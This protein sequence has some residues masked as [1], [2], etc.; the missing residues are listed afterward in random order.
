MGFFLYQKNE[1]QKDGLV[2][3]LTLFF[4]AFLFRPA[5]EPRPTFYP[6]GLLYTQFATRPK[7]IEFCKYEAHNNPSSFCPRLY[8]DL[9]GHLDQT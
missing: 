6:L 2:L 1:I 3:Q 7:H 5:A 9:L 4:K 8:S